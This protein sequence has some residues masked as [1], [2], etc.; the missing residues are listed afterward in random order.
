MGGSHSNRVD[1]VTD[2]LNESIQS[3]TQDC[4]KIEQAKNTAVIDGDYNLGRDIKQTAIA[5]INGSCVTDAT[6]DSA[7]SNDISTKI[8]QK[9][10]DEGVALTQFLDT[11]ET[12]NSINMRTN[13]SNIISNS[14]SQKC[15]NNADGINLTLIRGSGNILDRVDQTARASVVSNCL[16]GNEQS[17]AAT[18]DIVNSATQSSET[19]SKNPMS[20]IGD[21]LNAMVKAGMVGIAGILVIMI[22]FIFLTKFIRHH[23]SSTEDTISNIGSESSKSITSA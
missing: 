21:A 17:A 12:T 18:N 3:A 23:G 22:C 19:V 11:T 14:A 4:V 15:I 20:F 13:I 8:R 7:F 16:M 1:V 10:K 9:L 2:V 6:Q 5:K